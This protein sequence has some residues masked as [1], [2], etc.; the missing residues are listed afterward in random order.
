MPVPRRFDPAA[1]PEGKP[2]WTSDL[3][4][5]YEKAD[6][7]TR[8]RILLNAGYDPAHEQEV[9]RLFPDFVSSDLAQNDCP[10]KHQQH[11]HSVDS[12]RKIFLLFIKRFW[13]LFCGLSVIVGVFSWEWIL[14]FFSW[15]LSFLP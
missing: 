4:E 5:D 6:D 8:R 15:L 10:Q 9:I 1:N 7:E 14:H 12:P 11:K 2:E 3:S 13:K